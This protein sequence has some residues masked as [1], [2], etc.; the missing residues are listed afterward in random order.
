MS[1]G[2]RE[3]SSFMLGNIEGIWNKR[4]HR[5]A[6]D[7]MPLAQAVD[8]L[9]AMWIG[10]TLFTGLWLATGIQGSEP[11]LEFRPGRKGGSLANFPVARRALDLVMGRVQRKGGGPMKLHGHR[12]GGNEKAVVFNPVAARA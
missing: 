4:G 6:G 5:V 11:L 7:A 2:E 1:A 9:R 10:M 3:A 8:E 12:R